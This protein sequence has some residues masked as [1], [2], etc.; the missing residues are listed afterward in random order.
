MTVF[1]SSCDVKIDQGFKSQ[2]NPQIV[3]LFISLSSDGFNNH[4]G[5]TKIH[6]F[7]SFLML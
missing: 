4:D 5:S 7:I 6:N 3:E 2:P 1:L